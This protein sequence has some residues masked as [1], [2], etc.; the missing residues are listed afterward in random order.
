M[1]TYAPAVKRR[2]RMTPAE[3]VEY[4]RAVEWAPFA[5]GFGTGAE[6]PILVPASDE[7]GSGFR[8]AARIIR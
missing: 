1:N 5:E 6:T 2:E 8:P 3:R 4:D 7:A